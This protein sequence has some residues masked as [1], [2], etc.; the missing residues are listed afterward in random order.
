VEIDVSVFPANESRRG[1]AEV[2]C[3]LLLL[4]TVTA[5]EFE[6]NAKPTGTI[7][8]RFRFRDIDVSFR[9]FQTRYS[10]K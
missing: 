10:K 6:L 4:V 1:H 5:F 8:L 2:Y 7:S 9:I 3:T